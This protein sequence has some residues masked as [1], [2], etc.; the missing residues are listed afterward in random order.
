MANSYVE[1]SS[2]LTATTYSIPFK[3]IAITDVAV[4]GYNGTTWSTLAI[5]SR[6]NAAKTV[7][8]SA[9]PS[10]YQK[11]RVWRN[12]TRSQLVDFQNGSRLSESDL[13]TA[14]QQGLFVAQEVSEVAS[15]LNEEF[16]IDRNFTG[17]TTVVDL[18]AS[19]D[20]NVTG[21]VHT[22]KLAVN[23]T[24]ASA[25]LHINGSTDDAF[26]D[27]LRVDKKDTPTQFAQ[28]NYA[29]SGLN[30]IAS[31][32]SNLSSYGTPALGAGNPYI[33][34]KTS[35]DAS[36]ATEHMR[37]DKD[38]NVGIGENDPK[39]DL[40]VKQSGST[41]TPNA[42]TVALFQRNT[43]TGSG[44]MVSILSGNNSAADLNFADADDEDVGRIRY[45]HSDNSM[46]FQT[47]TAERMR[48]DSSGHVLIA[49]TDITPWT[50][51]ANSSADK[52]IALRAE[53]FIA[54]ANY[55][56]S[57][58]DL[59]RTGSDGN[60]INFYK[61][62]SNIGS[63]SVTS[64]A[65][66][67]NTSSDYRLKENVTD[68]TDGITRV[69]QL[70]PKRFNFIVD[71]DTTVDGFLAHEAQTVV[72]EA[73]H[74]TKDEVEIWADGDELP[75]GVSVGDNKLDDDGKT[76]PVMQG[77][78]QSKLVPLLTAALQEAIAK[79]EVLETKVAAL[80]A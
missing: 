57:P 43:V 10:T 50:N 37:I 73:V 30:I 22:D 14:Y 9:A 32:S 41:F 8:L 60:M 1:Y 19:G 38:G 2:G 48:I 3:Y 64:S 70:S 7:T 6:D 16:S 77:I 78:D 24:S 63:I 34:L 72:P 55:S 79:I 51:N 33:C 67:Y 4:K 58:M 21:G 52:G 62:G 68:V 61:S 39:A 71:A 36:T 74:G 49:T 11:I 15:T 20:L 56:S 80:E 76:I 54:A 59:N 25:D 35:V 26:Y 27:G 18:E 28:F 5:A 13:D 17:T 75:D 65:T 66:A 12:T 29:G 42:N 44:A 31:D 23:K 53:G 45:N 46:Q 47:N 40:V 69:K